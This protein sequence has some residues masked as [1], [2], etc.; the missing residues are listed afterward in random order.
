MQNS[1]L[2]LICFDISFMRIEQCLLSLGCCTCPE[3]F[4][5][6]CQI[7]LDNFLAEVTCH[8]IGQIP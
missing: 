4:V 6:S 3:T 1:V 7:F 2:N 5:S 8:K